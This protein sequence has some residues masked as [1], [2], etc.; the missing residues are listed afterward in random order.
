[1][2]KT[3]QMAQSRYSEDLEIL[4]NKHRNESIC[5]YAYG[6]EIL[7]GDCGQVYP[8]GVCRI[9]KKKTYHLKGLH[10]HLTGSDGMWDSQ[11]YIDGYKNGRPMFR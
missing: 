6:T 10:S 5:V 3:D 8:C 9:E 11:F 2:N 4:L 7:A 1:M